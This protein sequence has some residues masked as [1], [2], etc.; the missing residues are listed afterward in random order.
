MKIQP[1]HGNIDSSSKLVLKTK[2]AHGKRKVRELQ[3]AGEGAAGRGFHCAGGMGGCQRLGK[4][5]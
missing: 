2:T 5:C 3:G 4:G 1:A